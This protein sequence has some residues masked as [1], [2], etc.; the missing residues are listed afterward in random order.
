MVRNE[1]RTLTRTLKRD[2]ERNLTFNIKSNPKAFWRYIN[3]RLKVHSTIGDLQCPDG[4]TVHLDKD[5]AEIPNQFFTSVF[6]HK[7]L[8]VIPSFTL[9]HAVPSLHTVKIS[10]TIVHKKLLDIN[11][12]KSPGPKCWPLLA[13]KETAEQMCTPLS[14]LFK[15]SLQS[16]ILP[17]DCKSAQVTPIFKKGNRHSPNNYQPI[18]LTS[19][20]ARLFESIIKHKIYDHLNLHHLL[21]TDQHG[22]VAGRSCITQI[23]Y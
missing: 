6:T 18:S 9:D 17:Q 3:S 23:L 22:F 16:G 4:S 21:F 10:P 14:I 2:F 19:P 15:K 20:V 7:K 11:P 13:L 1:L 5:K 12:N 8:S